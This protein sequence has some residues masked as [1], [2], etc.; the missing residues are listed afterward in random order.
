[1]AARPNFAAGTGAQALHGRRHAPAQLYR[2]ARALYGVI[3]KVH[4]LFPGARHIEMLALICVIAKARFE[5]ATCDVTY[6]AAELAMPRSTLHRHLKQF[7]AM[8]Y[9]TTLREGRRTLV[10]ATE[11]GYEHGLQL[12]ETLLDHFAPKA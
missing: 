3:S 5:G 2:A 9:V 12:L 10:D 4:Q 11:S 8:G 1:M 6:V 7:Q